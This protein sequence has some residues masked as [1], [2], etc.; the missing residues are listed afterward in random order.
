MQTLLGN[1]GSDPSALHFSIN[2]I[3]K[4]KR[5]PDIPRKIRQKETKK[6]KAE[7]SKSSSENYKSFTSVP[8]LVHRYKNT[9]SVDSDDTS[10]DS[11]LPHL[12]DRPTESLSE[13]S[14]NY[15]PPD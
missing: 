15:Y 2:T 3:S 10:N 13:T 1:P 11:A 9:D 14:T 7:L 5:S 8:V 12:V 4:G 6:P